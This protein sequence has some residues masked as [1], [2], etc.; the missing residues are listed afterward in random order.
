MTFEIKGHSATNCIAGKARM[1]KLE[2]QKVAPTCS[3]LANTDFLKGFGYYPNHP[4]DQYGKKGDVYIGQVK[5]L[6]SNLD[7]SIKTELTAFGSTYYH[8]QN[9]L[10]SF[11]TSNSDILS[12]NAVI[13]NSTIAEDVKEFQEL[14]QKLTLDGNFENGLN[15]VMGGS[16]PSL[17]Q[18]TA[19]ADVFSD[20]YAVSCALSPGFAIECI[21]LRLAKTD[22]VKLF[23]TTM[24]LNNMLENSVTRM[25]ELANKI[26]E[27]TKEEI[28]ETTIDE[29]LLDYEVGVFDANVLE[30]I[31]TTYESVND[32]YAE[33]VLHQSEASDS[34][35]I[36]G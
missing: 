26:A 15:L 34:T 21:N 28:Y 36:G 24:E 9:Q 3:A 22:L 18:D 13:T 20:T 1:Q 19:L 12:L 29:D 6:I 32:Y 23:E 8:N 35:Y 30:D 4:A 31:E 7:A 2:L 17:L 16:S 33:E 27:Y 14:R 11:E 5:S 25:H 10:Q